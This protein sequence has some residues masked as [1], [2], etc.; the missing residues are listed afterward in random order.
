M[1]EQ[2]GT[3]M[4]VVDDLPED[5]QPGLVDYED[6]LFPNNNRRRVPGYLYLSISA[7]VLLL[8]IYFR[9]SVFVNPGVI[10]AALGLGVFGAYSIFAGVDLKID[11]RQALAKAVPAFGHT[12]GHASAQMSWHRSLSL[13]VWR[14]LLYSAENPPSHRGFVVV[15]ATTG[16]VLEAISEENPEDWNELSGPGA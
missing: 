4:S 10:V 1:T 15:D 5:L 2:G 14:I 12:V 8:C 7:V 6:Y 3:E 13:P 16:A 9:E 11:E